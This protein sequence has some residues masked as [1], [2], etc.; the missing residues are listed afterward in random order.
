[1]NQIPL[2]PY[3]CLYNTVTI[4][5]PYCINKVKDGMTRAL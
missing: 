3:V 2:D 1:M 5:C 4:S